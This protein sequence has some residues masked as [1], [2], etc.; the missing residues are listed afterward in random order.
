MRVHARLPEDLWPE[1]MPAAAYVLNRTPNRQLDWKTPL[2]ELQRL[3]NISNPRPSIAHLRVYGAR[4][5]PL[6][7]NI[8]KSEKL[9][10]RAHIGY[11][12]GYDSTNIFRIWIPSKQRVIRTRDVTFNETLFYDPALPDITQLLR[13]E[14]EQIVEVVDMASSQ[15]LTDGLDLDIDS[16]SDLD[17]DEPIEQLDSQDSQ[18][19][20]SDNSPDHRLPTPAET[21]ASPI[22]TP[23]RQLTP[24][25][26]AAEP[27]GSIDGQ[28]ELTPITDR[29]TA[30]RAQEI[31]S[32]FSEENIIANRTRHRRQAY[33]T[34]LQQPEQ[35]HAYFSAFAIGL[36]R[37]HRDQLPP[38]PRS[39]RELQSHPNREGF[40]AAAEKE[41]R[42]LERRQTFRP[43]PK[44]PDLKLLPLMWVF[45]YKFDT[46]GFLDKYKARLCVRGDLQD[47]TQLDTYA[48]TLAARIFRTL[49]AIMAAFDL[50]ARQYD[51]VNA[52]T[53]SSLDEVV[54]CAC[55][56]GYNIEGLCLLL[57]CALYGLR[58]SPLLWLKEFSKTLQ[59][60]GLQ[61]VPGEPC[62]FTNDWLI[63]FFYVDDI[64]TLCRKEH[65]PRL[66]NFEKS[67][68]ARYEIRS[69]GEL[70]WFLGIRVVRD[71]GAKKVWLCQD[72]YID[73]ITTRFH[74]EHHKPAHTPLPPD[75]LL[76]YEGQ[77]T[78]QQIHAYQQRVGSI[79]FPAVI[80]C[81]D[82]ALSASRLATFLSNPS[83][84][85]TAAADQTITYLN[86]T[87]TLAIEYSAPTL[88]DEQR[89]FFCASDAAFADDR[90]TRKST[91][92]YLYKLFGGPADWH[93]MKQ[94]TVTTSSTEAELLALTYATKETI[95]WRRFFKHIGFN[96]GHEL[97]VHCDNLQT[98]RLLTKEN[99]KLATKLRHVDIHQHWL[100]QEVQAGRIRVNWL[101]TNEMPADGLTKALPRQRHEQF[102]KQLNLTDIRTRIQ[103]TS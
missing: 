99:Q 82:V 35:L 96:P 78:A 65:L 84:A 47:P 5:Y 8:P 54:H 98:I 4:A 10:P 13:A 66:A 41:Y 58:R 85:H 6:T 48:T 34:V 70:S 39:W 91:S 67:L 75:E 24:S 74:L 69:L 71:R 61:E 102:I 36:R 43:V 2:E 12:V 56:E 101:P 77:A 31:S 45:T 18:D 29:N 79:N 64:V 46:N 32:D 19:K 51:A 89:I 42:D 40:L 59:E 93:S 25:T 27:S 55:P 7:P 88:G 94:K 50:E 68:M 100:R 73:K 92:G 49:M 83:P 60:L 52:F 28:Q 21:T 26:A 15:P 11:L 33:L 57:L 37:L 95:W 81:P 23:D 14:V 30:P 63:V 17:L 62:L 90:E 80:T 87:K 9:K 86:G 76:P 1:I 103:P 97:T 3:L 20:S 38:P 44:T 53:N 16:D 72:S 22:S